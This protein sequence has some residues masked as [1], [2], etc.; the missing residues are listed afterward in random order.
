MHASNPSVN[1]IFRIDRYAVIGHPVSHSQSPWIHTEFAR[2]TQQ[3]LE[4]TRLPAP[5]DGFVATATAFAEQGGQGLNVTLPFKQAAHAMANALSPR[6][7]MAGAVNTLRVE[8]DNTL[9]KIHWYGD[10]TD[11]IGLVRDLARHMHRPLQAARVLV[12]G[13][14]GAARGALATLIETQP[15]E[16]V[17][18]NR[19]IARAEALITHFAAHAAAYQCRLHTAADTQQ[20]GAFDLIINAS[21]ASLEGAQLDIDPSAWNTANTLAYDM[22]YSANPTP[23]MQQAWDHG[24]HAVDGLGMLVEQAAESFYLWRGVHPHIEP[25]LT[26]LRDKL[27][28][29]A[30]A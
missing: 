16:I 26:A 18:L 1:D 23:F 21:S 5:P 6:A 17:I 27:L 24:A 4:Y 30:A 14:G 20:L 28:S 29:S 25:V 8:R 22:M 15:A 11:G 7:A 19:T 9:G 10:N 3:I 13:A 2:Q 12:L